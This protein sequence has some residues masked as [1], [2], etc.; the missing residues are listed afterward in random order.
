MSDSSSFFKAQDNY[1]TIK[2]LNE[3]A[4][5]KEPRPAIK[6]VLIKLFAH[7]TL[8]LLETFASHVVIP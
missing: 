2:V 5:S 1:K 6:Q 3:K 7:E 4:N 8:K